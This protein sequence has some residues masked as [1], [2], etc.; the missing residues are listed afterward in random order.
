MK[1]RLLRGF[2]S[3]LSSAD[4]CRYARKDKGNSYQCRNKICLWKIGISSIQEIISEMPAMEHLPGKYI[5]VF[6]IRTQ[7]SAEVFY[8]RMTSFTI[9]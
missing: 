7:G 9:Q 5:V 6:E 2:S 1:E 8:S 3:R 4:A